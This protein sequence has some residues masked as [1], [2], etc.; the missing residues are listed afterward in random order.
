M[1]NRASTTFKKPNVQVNREKKTVSHERQ[2]KQTRSTIKDIAMSKSKPMPGP[3]LSYGKKNKESRNE[4]KLAWTVS[5]V[6][7]IFLVQLFLQP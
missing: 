4:I 5:E 1:H 3:L 7:K 2:T 6:Y